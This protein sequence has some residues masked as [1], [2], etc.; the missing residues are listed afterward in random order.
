VRYTALKLCNPQAISITRSANLSRVLR[1][2]SLT[3]RHRLTPHITCLTA[4]RML[5]IREFCSFSSR[6][7][8]LPRGYT[9]RQPP[10]QNCASRCENQELPILGVTVSYLW[11][12]ILVKC[13]R[14][15]QRHLL[16]LPLVA[17]VT[18][19]A[20]H[21]WLRFP[22]F[23]SDSIQDHSRPKIYPQPGPDCHVY[24]YSYHRPPSSYAFMLSPWVDFSHQNP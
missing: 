22:G 4:M 19:P 14:L 11:M 16:V 13:L 20:I 5:G 1:N 8:S 2:T 23:R 17:N 21:R 18:Y 24:G 15:T 10:V 7:N 3:I 6:V 9:V 12:F